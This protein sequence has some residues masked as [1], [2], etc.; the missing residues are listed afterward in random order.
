MRKIEHLE[1]SENP[2]KNKNFKIGIFFKNMIILSILKP[3]QVD[4]RFVFNLTSVNLTE[5]DSAF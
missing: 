5:V 3:T 4:N 2:N 1:L